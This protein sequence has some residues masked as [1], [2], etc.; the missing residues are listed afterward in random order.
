MTLRPSNPSRST[1]N[2]VKQHQNPSRVGFSAVEMDLEGQ[3]LG[4]TKV[5]DTRDLF[6]WINCK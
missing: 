2:I 5:R 4:E 1:T 6:K 3:K